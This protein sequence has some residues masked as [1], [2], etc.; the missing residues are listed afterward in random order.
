MYEKNFKV[1]H[2]YCS[3]S[4]QTLT[5]T[6]RS[7]VRLTK[8]PTP[9]LIF[10]HQKPFFFCGRITRALSSLS[11]RPRLLSFNKHFFHEKFRFTLDVCFFKKKASNIKKG[12]NK[13]KFLKIKIQKL[14]TIWIT[15]ISHDRDS[16]TCFFHPIAP[17]PP[18]NRRREDPIRFDNFFNIKKTLFSSDKGKRNE[19]KRK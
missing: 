8:Y 12:A 10:T 2:I 19:K 6:S 14:T 11:I 5:K 13:Q 9:L 18:L 17:P 7:F 15:R 3:L 1:K 4:N 16:S